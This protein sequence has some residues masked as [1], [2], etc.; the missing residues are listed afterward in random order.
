MKEQSGDIPDVVT[1]GVIV[2]VLVELPLDDHHGRRLVLGLV[3]VRDRLMRSVSRG[4]DEP[5]R[6]RH[7]DHDVVQAHVR[8]VDQIHREDL[9][10]HLN[11][12]RIHRSRATDRGNIS[13]TIASARRTRR[14]YEG[15]NGKVLA[16]PSRG[17]G[18]PNAGPIDGRT[19]AKCQGAKG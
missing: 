15:G 2:L 4:Q 3:A 18:S 16:S 14:L 12:H 17:F 10:A 9:V 7:D 8:H 19:R 11:I 6:Y 5:S 1:R 13:A